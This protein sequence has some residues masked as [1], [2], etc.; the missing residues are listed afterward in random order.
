MAVAFADAL[1]ASHGP[2]L[3]VQTFTQMVAKQSNM[4]TKTLK[5]NDKF[6][7]E[8]PTDQKHVV[9]DGLAALDQIN[10][11]LGKAR[12]HATDWNTDPN[13]L[14]GMIGTNENIYGHG[15]LISAALS[16]L[17]AALQKAKESGDDQQKRS[18]L[19]EA[20]DQLKTIEQDVESYL[21]SVEK[22][23]KRLGTFQA[24]IEADYRAFDGDNTKVVALLNGDTG[25]LNTISSEIDALHSAI[26]KDNAMIAGGAV[27]IAAGVIAGVVGGIL[28]ATGVGTGVG[29]TVIAG[30]VLTAGGG[31][32]ITTV[33]GIDL[34]KKQ[35]ELASA[36]T[37]LHVLHACV[38]SFNSAKSVL[39]QLRDAAKNA[40]DGASQ[41]RAAWGGQQ[42]A[43]QQEQH[44]IEAA[45][46]AGGPQIDLALT[47]AI[48]FTK[49]ALK[50]WAVVQKNAGNIRTALTGLAD[51]PKTHVPAVELQAA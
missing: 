25:L 7:D 33:A 28:I 46:K 20:Q 34:K 30:G 36:E 19:S 32:A 50:E 35:G 38:T 1:K 41:L 44:D 21:E 27:M 39:G 24:D 10:T 3:A 51:E 12:S 11:H 2:G 40:A 22:L 16:E 6:K 8:L 42:A 45:L 29:L 49:A 17:P 48:D 9:D 5:E 47:K 37:E 14:Q 4:D 26:A 23:V 31:V 13:L 15:D 43:L 18:A